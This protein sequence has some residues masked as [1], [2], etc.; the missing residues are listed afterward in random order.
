MLRATSKALALG[1][2]TS[3][4]GGAL[5]GAGVG[6]ITG[7]IEGGIHGAGLAAEQDKGAKEIALAG[8]L[9]AGIGILAGGAIGSITGGISGMIR[10]RK[11]PNKILEYITPKTKELSSTEYEKL[12]AQGKITPKTATSP[13]QY[14]LSKS[15]KETALR[16]AHTINKDPVKTVLNINNEISSIDDDVGRFLKQNNGI[17]NKGEVKNY[18]RSYIDDITDITIDERRLAKGKDLL[19]E[20][21]IKEI[22]KGDMESLWLARK[23]F[24]QQIEKAF[25]GSPTLQKELKIGVRNAVQDFIA[26]NTPD[27]VYKG[28]MKDMSQLFRLRDNAI[29]KAVKEKSLGTIKLWMKNHPNKTKLVW[30][31]SGAI[32]GGLIWDK[33]RGKGASSK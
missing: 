16:F 20:N 18:I 4:A 7:G 27:T 10:G 12:L 13:A 28:L 9:G 15:E 26:E 17:F 30:G 1:K 25:S 23:N 31:I 2:A 3:F 19:S 14:V 24:D 33:I 29:T 21:F 22:Q 11:D 5:R 6:A 32:T 8:G